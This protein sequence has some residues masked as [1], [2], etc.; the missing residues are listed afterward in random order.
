[1]VRW[2]LHAENVVLDLS[3][4]IARERNCNASAGGPHS[5]I[6]EF[7]FAYSRVNRPYRVSPM[8]T[9]PGFAPTLQLNPRLDQSLSDLT[10]YPNGKNRLATD[11]RIRFTY[12]SES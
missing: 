5:E 11:E 3:V 7:Q 4:L 9:G 10:S 1:M 8:G 2:L 6:A 12:H